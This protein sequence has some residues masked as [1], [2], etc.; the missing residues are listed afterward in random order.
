MRKR[1]SSRT[2]VFIAVLVGVLV[3]WIAPTA[4]RTIAEFARDSDRVDGFHAVG[5]KNEKRSRRLVATDRDGHLPEAIVEHAQNARKLGGFPVDRYVTTCERGSIAGYAQVPSAIG[6][7]WAEVTGYGSTFAAGGPTPIPG[8]PGYEQCTFSTPE[9]R[10]LST[11]TYEV[12]L[13]NDEAYCDFLPEPAVVV[14]V[15][16]P[17]PLFASYQG[18]CDPDRGVTE[19]VR[20]FDED[21]VATDAGFTI[22]IL[23]SPRT[24]PIP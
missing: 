17:R 14:T 9:A 22:T 6:S 16:D 21:G 2:K 12:A 24:I 20:I 10:R 18:A 23:S 1:P 13:S 4:A 8:E 3:G 7:E 19:V 5:A 11:G 15:N